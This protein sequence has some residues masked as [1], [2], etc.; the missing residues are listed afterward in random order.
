MTE[1]CSQTILSNCSLHSLDS[2]TANCSQT[3]AVQTSNSVQTIL[4]EDI[5]MHEQTS[6]SK[7]TRKHARAHTHTRTHT[8]MHA[9]NHS[10]KQDVPYYY[11]ILIQRAYTITPGHIVNAALSFRMLTMSSYHH[12]YFG[13][14]P[15][16]LQ[17]TDASPNAQNSQCTK[18][19]VSAALLNSLS[20]MSRASWGS[21]GSFS[22]PGNTTQ[23]FFLFFF[24]KFRFYASGRITQECFQTP[25][26]FKNGPWSLKLLSFNLCDLCASKQKR[27]FHPQK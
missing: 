12:V 4:T 7:N 22:K 16:T 2:V 8:H 26:S 23:Y 21:V 25:A 15:T 9:H 14:L 27:D 1:N 13:S 18:L 24:F 19:P 17:W 6:V 5:P 10:P 3:T 11:Y 20:K